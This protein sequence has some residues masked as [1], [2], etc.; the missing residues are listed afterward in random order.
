MDIIF[1]T[2]SKNKLN[3]VRGI[4]SDCTITNEKLDIEEIQSFELEE[5]AKDKSRKAYGILKKPVLTEDTGFYIEAPNGLPGPFIKFFEQRM[6]QE[7]T[8]LLTKPYTNKTAVARTCVCFYDGKEFVISIGEVRGAVL[9]EPVVADDV[10]GFDGCFV[11]EG[12]DKTFY[13]Y[14]FTQTLVSDFLIP[15]SG[16]SQFSGISSHF[17]PASIPCS[18]SP[19]SSS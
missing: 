5:I 18:I 1:V 6:G 16:H 4:L 10:F 17:V 12:Y 13:V 3:E 15:Q 9:D 14:S 19:F 11:P 8:S 2:G 7:A